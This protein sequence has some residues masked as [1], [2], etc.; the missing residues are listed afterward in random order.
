MSAL[1]SVAVRDQTEKIIRVYWQVRSGR[2]L[3]EFS[4]SSGYE[5]IVELAQLA[6]RRPKE[7]IKFCECTC[8][9]AFDHSSYRLGRHE[10]EHP[11]C[12]DAKF[13]KPFKRIPDRRTRVDHISKD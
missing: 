2:V 7:K 6:V 5:G 3:E 1:P 9:D 8:S 4:D 12:L 13:R 10:C 11:D